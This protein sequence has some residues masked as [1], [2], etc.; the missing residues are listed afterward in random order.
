MLKT[1]LVSVRL[2]LRQEGDFAAIHRFNI[3]CHMSD[4]W[5]YVDGAFTRN[6]LLP[7]SKHAPDGRKMNLVRHSVQT[8]QLRQAA[9]AKVCARVHNHGE[10]L[11]EKPQ[12]RIMN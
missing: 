2:R 10:P 4:Q 5:G 7:M 11:G 8:L 3:P 1:D 12:S 6:H 9:E